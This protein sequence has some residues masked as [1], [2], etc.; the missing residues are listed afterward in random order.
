PS[1]PEP[2]IKTGNTSTTPSTPPPTPVK[3][4]ES[5][6]TIS[7]YKRSDLKKGT[8]IRI[9]RLFFQADKADIRESS[10]E[11]LDEVYTFLKENEDV[12]IEVGGHTNSIPDHPFC[13]SLSTARAK[14]VAEYLIQKGIDENQIQYKGYG[15]R[16]LLN[17]NANTAMERRKNQRV[18]IKI[19]SMNS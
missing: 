17:P 5:T 7:G 4:K 8:E 13:D 15:K 16:K 1:R 2:T 12:V 6:A 19:L 10:F 3:V 9:D 11:A 18:E 14:A